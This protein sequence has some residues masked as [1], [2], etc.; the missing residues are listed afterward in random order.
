MSIFSS[1]LVEARLTLRV[2][3]HLLRYPDAELR[4]HIPELQQALRS[5]RA[6]SASRMCMAIRVTAARP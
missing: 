5:E 2:L 1:P 4:A 6:L 3:G